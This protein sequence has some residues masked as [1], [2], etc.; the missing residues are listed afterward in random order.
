M[1]NSIET[2]GLYAFWKH[3]R[4]P[5]LLGGEVTRMDDDG[6]VETKEF[7]VG[8]WYRPSKLMPVERGRLLRARLKKLEQEFDRAKDE[9]RHEWNKKIADVVDFADVPVKRETKK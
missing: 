3:D 9:L 6:K 1:K 2:N 8:Y 4:F 5:F 7:G